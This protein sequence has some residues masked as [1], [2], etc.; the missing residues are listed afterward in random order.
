[1]GASHCRTPKYKNHISPESTPKRSGRPVPFLINVAVTARCGENGMTTQKTTIHASSCISPI[2]EIRGGSKKMWVLSKHAVLR[3]TSLRGKKTVLVVKLPMVPLRKP[4][5]HLEPKQF[6]IDSPV[7]VDSDFPREKNTDS[8]KSDHYDISH[9]PHYIPILL[10]TS[11]L[12]SSYSLL[13]YI[14]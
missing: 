8:E 9:Y 6:S 12:H 13:N 14:G 5:T 4:K 10:F 7:I 11:L 2:H 1:M 3:W